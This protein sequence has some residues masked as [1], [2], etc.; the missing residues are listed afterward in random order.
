M[1]EREI[2]NSRRLIEIWNKAP[3][4]WMIV[5]KTEETP[6]IYGENFPDLMKKRIKLMQKYRNR[7]PFIDRKFMFRVKNSP[8]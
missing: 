6:F 7:E 4:D 1:I 2:E 5:S 8:F 3:I